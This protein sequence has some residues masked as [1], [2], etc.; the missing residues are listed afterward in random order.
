MQI[1]ESIPEYLTVMPYN[2]NTAYKM[3]REES[4]VR[5]SKILSDEFSSVD[6]LCKHLTI[7][8]IRR[9]NELLLTGKYDLR[10]AMDEVKDVLI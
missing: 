5:L 4:I 10:Q 2:A 9:I 7:G 6:E 8:Q 1:P 3:K